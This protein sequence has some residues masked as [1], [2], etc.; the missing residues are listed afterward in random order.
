MNK[1]INFIEL[2]DKLNSR[3]YCVIKLDPEFPNY[4]LGQDID[5]FC[6]N[7]KEVSSDI[8]SYLSKY[9]D[10]NF[11]IQVLKKNEQIQI[12]LLEDKIIH[13]RFDLFSKL[14]KYSVIQVK[15]SFF[16]VLIETSQ[17]KKI[18]KFYIKV[19]NHVNEC[20]I[21]YFEFMQYYKETPDKIKHLEFIEKTL[22]NEESLDKNLFFEKLNHFTLITNNQNFERGL[23]NKFYKNYKYFHLLYKKSY[24]IYKSEGFLGFVKKV[25]KYIK[26]N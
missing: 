4:S 12:D 1:K 3:A 18:D 21:R 7:I 6:Y 14:P 11:K 16:D 22:Q 8:I 2:F 23:V 5:I 9:V 20:L 19:P 24:E 25:K 13:F 26:K 17:T 10:K 15:P